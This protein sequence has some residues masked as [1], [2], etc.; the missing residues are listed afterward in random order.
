MRIAVY[1]NLPSGGAKRALL[2]FTSRLSDRHRFDVFT[3]MSA[4]HDFADLRPFVE[5]HRTFEFHPLP[6]MKSPFGRI[7]NG[8]RIIDLFRLARIGRSVARRIESTGYDVAFVHPC[9]FENSPSVISAL[10]K[11]P[12][13]F[14][15]QEPL[16]VL[17][18]DTPSR[19]YLAEH[20]SRR[21]HL[22]RLDP[23]PGLYRSLLKHRDRSNLMRAD[24]VLVNSEFSRENIRDTY[25]VDPLVS[26][27]GVD[28]EK[29]RPTGI[30]KERILLSVGSMTPLKGF[31][32]LVRATARLPEGKR[33]P[34]YIISNFE[35]PP[36]RRYMEDL[37]RELTVDLRL[38]GNVDEE[39]LVGLYNRATAVVYAP[40]REP[41]GLVPIEAMSCGTPVVA[42]REGGVQESVLHEHT[43]F[44]TDRDPKMFAEAVERLLDDPALAD[45]FG[46]NGRDHVEQHWS[47][48]R[49]TAT[50]EKHLAVSAGNV[51]N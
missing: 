21:K 22:D 39:G 46:R 33:P 34:L 25:G 16:R 27:L 6:L 9:R 35:N 10:T 51:L 23:L 48:D 5:N 1:H 49:A 40:I 2:E 38:V 18:E 29:F 4:D 7:N 32:F 43:G 13:V 42:V 17:Y 24:S 37:S 47:W 11:L 31:D 44:L 20:A 45:E 14:Y 15:C 26:Y 3:L 30:G 12:A 28:I 50:L 8:A 41:F 36:E 19:P